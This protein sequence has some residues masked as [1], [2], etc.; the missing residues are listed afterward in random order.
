LTLDEIFDKYDRNCKGVLTEHELRKM[1]EE[2]GVKKNRQA[3]SESELDH[4]V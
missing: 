1:L 4:L 3:P 2:M